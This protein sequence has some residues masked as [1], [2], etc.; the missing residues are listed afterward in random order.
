MMLI[1]AL[2]ICCLP[3]TL[4]SVYYQKY[5]ARQWCV[6]CCTVQ[7]L[8]WLEFIPLHLFLQPALLLHTAGWGEALR[9]LLV[10]ALIP[11]LGWRYLKPVILKMQQLQPV[12]EQLRKFKFNVDV[13]QQLLSAQP[14]LSQPEPDWSIVIGEREAPHV[15][16]LVTN[17]YCPPC[18]EA[19]SFLNELIGTNNLVQARI[20]FNAKNADG[21]VLAPVTR[22][23]MALNDLPDKTIAQ[24]ALHDWYGQK[25]KDF[26]TWA[27]AHPVEL[28]AS[29]FYKL[30]KQYEWCQTAEIYAT[31][32]LFINGH[33]LPEHYYLP[34]LKYMLQ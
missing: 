6:L 16:T 13:F 14:Q 10:C 30:D 4:Y 29:G 23:L 27:E 22:H 11:L 20:I 9:T 18:A 33:R 28:R 24:Q 25:Q 19:H 32:S 5:I 31:P 1:A 34:D 17:P 7:A 21:D 2:N 15:I 8:F 26:K 3:Y 12:K